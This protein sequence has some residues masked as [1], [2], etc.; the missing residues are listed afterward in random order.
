MEGGRSKELV[1]IPDCMIHNCNYR[2]PIATGKR[3]G[4][5]EER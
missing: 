3:E 2:T 5:I 1:T 4:G